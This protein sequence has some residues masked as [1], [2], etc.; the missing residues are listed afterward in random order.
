MSF[1]WVLVGLDVNS[2]GSIL[3]E[4]LIAFMVIALIVGI[5]FIYMEVLI[6]VK[7]IR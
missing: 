7:D 5:L 2:K 4:Y 3:I 1:N 6:F